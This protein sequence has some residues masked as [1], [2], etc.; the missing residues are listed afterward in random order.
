MIRAGAVMSGILG[1]IAAGAGVAG[2][3]AKPDPVVWASA[4]LDRPVVVIGPQVLAMDGLDQVVVKAEPYME[5]M[6]ARPSDAYAWLR[7][8]SSTVVR[9]LASWEVV[10]VLVPTL[11]RYDGADPS[12]DIWRSSYVSAGA[13]VI[14][15]EDVPPGYVVVVATKTRI[16]LDSVS[17]E[18]TRDPGNGWAWPAISGGAVLAALSLS[19]FAW[20]WLD[21]RPARAKVEETVAQI[22][23]AGDEPEPGGRRARRAARDKRDQESSSS[24]MVDAADDDD[25]DAKPRKKRGHKR[26]KDA[27]DDQ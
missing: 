15:P 24:V 26:A 5:T 14:R 10:D 2:L 23:K 18:M 7:G 4:P 11:Y 1:I 3:I 17:I 19:L 22:R 9:G 8:E 16:P 6:T 25:G 20:L 13:S 12:H 27:E 21:L